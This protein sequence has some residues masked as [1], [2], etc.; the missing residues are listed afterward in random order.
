MMIS[1][2]IRITAFLF[3]TAVFLTVGG[4]GTVSAATNV[5]NEEDWGG[6]ALKPWLGVGDH[7]WTTDGTEIKTTGVTDTLD[8]L[9]IAKK[10]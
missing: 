8:Y 4:I 7:T 5:L 10:G 6:V 9:L 2:K 1:K 3:L